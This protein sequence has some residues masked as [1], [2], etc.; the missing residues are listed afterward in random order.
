MSTVDFKALLGTK[1]GDVKLPSP[2]PPGPWRLKVTKP[3]EPGKSSQKET[4]R[5]RVGFTFQ[6]AMDGVDP[7]LV[8][9]WLGENG[10]LTKKSIND[11]FY[12]T[13]DAT[14]RFVQFGR[15]AGVEDVDNK[16]LGEIASQLMNREIVAYIKHEPRQ[17]P[18]EGEPK[19]R[20]VID[21]YAPV[22]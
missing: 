4:P 15:H 13:E 8:K 9:E 1:A 5:L 19:F 10:V 22:G 12:L 3:V 14:F 20:A 16:T 18:R 6:E 17:N 21:R 7:D 11:D 2:P